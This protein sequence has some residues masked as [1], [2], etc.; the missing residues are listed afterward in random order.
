MLDILLGLYCASGLIV[1][2]YTLFLGFTTHIDAKRIGLKYPAFGHE[3]RMNFVRAAL[4]IYNTYLAVVMLKI[5][6][7]DLVRGP[8]YD[9]RPL[10]QELKE[11]DDNELRY[12]SAGSPHTSGSLCGRPSGAGCAGLPE[13][14]T[15]A[16][17]K[18][19]H[20]E[21]SVAVT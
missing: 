3:I 20:A 15:S 12:I 11:I 16:E 5:G 8:D 13:F 6:I 9:L 2:L 4:P 7:L 21:Q 18:C 17:N 19:R 14:D 1:I 10:L